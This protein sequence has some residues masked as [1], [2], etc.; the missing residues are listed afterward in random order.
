MPKT[1]VI[2]QL[3]DHINIINHLWRYFFEYASEVS[4]N[5]ASINHGTAYDCLPI[6]YIEC[7]Q[8]QRPPVEMCS[9]N[10]LC[11]VTYVGMKSLVR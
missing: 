3:E 7:I 6:L 5:V 8:N 2:V 9:F 11:I 4:L 10:A 1:I